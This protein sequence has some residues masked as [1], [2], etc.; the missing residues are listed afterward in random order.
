[1]RSVTKL[2]ILLKGIQCVEVL[3]CIMLIS[4]CIFLKNTR[5]M[6]CWQ[7]KQVLMESSYLTMAVSVLSNHSLSTVD[8]RIFIQVAKWNSESVMP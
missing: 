4:F 1:M 2:P 8:L 6:L 3:N 5:R 7:P